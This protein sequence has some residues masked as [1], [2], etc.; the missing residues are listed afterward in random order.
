MNTVTQRKTAVTAYF[1][2][3]QLLLF[4]FALYNSSLSYA[5]EGRGVWL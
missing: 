5:F 1:P 4:D 3:K 2:S